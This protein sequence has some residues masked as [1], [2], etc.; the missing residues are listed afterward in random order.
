MSDIDDR[1]GMQA[2]ETVRLM[3]SMCIWREYQSDDTDNIR[4]LASTYQLD[5]DRCVDQYGLL[6]NDQSV[7]HIKS[8]GS[9]VQH[10]FTHRMHE[11]YSV[12]FELACILLTIPVSSAGCERVF[13][14]LKLVKNELRSTMGDDRLNSLML[15]A[16]EKKIICET[17]LQ[18]FVDTFALKPRKL[19]LKLRPFAGC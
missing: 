18:I 15:M 2:T 9:L 17:N 1:C 14:K 19:K 8:L 6:R 11:T 4:R 3:S 7:K 13:S 5:S 10:M 16:V 12:V